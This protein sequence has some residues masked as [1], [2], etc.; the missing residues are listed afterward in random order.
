MIERLS[1]SETNAVEKF[2]F[3]GLQNIEKFIAPILKK[4]TGV[5]RLL[6]VEKDGKNLVFKFSDERS[7]TAR[8]FV[9]QFKKETFYSV[10]NIIEAKMTPEQ[11]KNFEEQGYTVISVVETKKVWLI[12]WAKP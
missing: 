9:K 10:P 8:A 11:L 6:D 4:E 5:R 3:S 2:N 7:E 1:V 12:F